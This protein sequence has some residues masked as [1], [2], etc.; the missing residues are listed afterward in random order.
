M[1]AIS[2]DRTN[3]NF[4]VQEDVAVLVDHGHFEQGN[5]VSFKFPRDVGGNGENS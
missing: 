5:S 4:H 3:A 2:I 1:S